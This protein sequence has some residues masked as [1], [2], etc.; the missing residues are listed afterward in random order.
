MSRASHG[1]G[2]TSV[3]AAVRWREGRLSLL[4]QRRLP[5]HVVYVGGEP[6]RGATDQVAEAVAIRREV[7][8]PIPTVPGI[9]ARNPAFDVTP[10]ELVAGWVTDRGLFSKPTELGILG[11]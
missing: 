1:T 4:D 6:V 2:S 3:P 5:A 9:R 8:E 10:A 11:A 7:A